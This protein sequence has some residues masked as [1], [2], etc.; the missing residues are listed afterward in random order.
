MSQYL[1]M[2]TKNWTYVIE[3]VGNYIVGFKRREKNFDIQ[4]IIVFSNT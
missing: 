3:I 2:A 1:S 4:Y